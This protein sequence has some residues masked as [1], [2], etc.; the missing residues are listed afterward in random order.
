MMQLVTTHD[1]SHTLYVPHLDEHYHSTFG[2]I[3]ESRHVF[4]DAGL[5]CRMAGPEISVLEVGFG[6]GL[7]ALLTC[8]AARDKKVKVTYHTLEKFPVDSVM[9]EKLNYASSLP[10]APDA[11]NL[12]AGIHQASWN[13][14]T[15]IHPF[16]HLHK[17]LDDLADFQPVFQ[18][19]LVYFDA[20][21][22]D[23]QPEMWTQ[24]IFNRLY[25]GLNPDGILITYC[26]KGTVKRMLKTAGFLIEKLPGPPGKREILRGKK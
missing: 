3:T 23:K 21:S 1:G 18:Y 2:A 7:N 10:Q 25:K 12:F 4:I 9:T 15:I 8:I 14:K 5:Y 13:E 26:V 22:P 17:I 19:D 11:E 20:F 6:T 24:A 16:F